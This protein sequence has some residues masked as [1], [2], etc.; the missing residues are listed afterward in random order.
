MVP[1]LLPDQHRK[2]V[3][4]QLEHWSRLPGIPPPSLQTLP[5]CSCCGKC[6]SHTVTT[7]LL[8]LRWDPAMQ[9]GLA[10]I[11]CVLSKHAW[12]LR[13]H[14]MNSNLTQWH[15]KRKK[16]FTCFLEVSVNSPGS[17]VFAFLSASKSLLPTASEIVCL[18][19]KAA[20]SWSCVLRW[21]KVLTQ[22]FHLLVYVRKNKE[23]NKMH[24]ERPMWVER[25]LS[26]FG[27]HSPFFCGS[28]GQS[29]AC[30]LH[31]TALGLI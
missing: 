27:E 7:A 28:F 9:G 2:P 4:E 1:S 3:Y 12:N 23:R 17:E 5:G 31:S 13:G 24:S 26:K 30:L 19:H 21:N 29:T 6:C 18:S 20:L 22:I 15:T 8:Y 11:G 10:G 14:G 16:K 25:T